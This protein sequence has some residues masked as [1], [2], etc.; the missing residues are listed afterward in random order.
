MS[1]KEKMTLTDLNAFLKGQHE[2]GSE[3]EDFIQKKPKTL[4]EVQALEDLKGDASEELLSEQIKTLAGIR[5]T[6]PRMILLD[7]IIYMMEKEESLNA[8][9]IM[10]LN[11]ALYVKHTEE[12]L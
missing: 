11:T 3:G 4:V 7:L 5:Q 1:K 8:S 10:L 2:D 6:A 9:D 12:N